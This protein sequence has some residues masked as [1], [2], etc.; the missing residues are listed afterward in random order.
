MHYRDANVFGLMLKR[1]RTEARL[2]QLQLAEIITCDRTYI[3]MIE[4][5]LR[6]PSLET[7]LMV[8]RA[9]GTSGAELITMLE[10]EVGA[11]ELSVVTPYDGSSKP[12]RHRFPW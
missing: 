9:F 7:V 10:H 5:G 12:H 1:M 11:E 4:R 8:A 3:S 6:H 2:S